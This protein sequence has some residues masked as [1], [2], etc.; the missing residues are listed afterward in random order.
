MILLEHDIIYA[1]LYL[2]ILMFS[3]DILKRKNF[4]KKHEKQWI[5]KTVP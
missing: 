5:M 4:L 1:I 3:S 2:I